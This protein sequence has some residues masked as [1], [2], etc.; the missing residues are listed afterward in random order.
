MN[1]FTA[2]EIDYVAIAPILI[3][4]IA[5]LLSVLT[6]TFLPRSVRRTVQILLTFLSLI[7]AFVVLVINHSIR[8]IT[9]GGAVAMA[10]GYL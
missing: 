7:G 8:T 3:V 4:A 6:E 1:T 2:P 9:G 5:A 10:P